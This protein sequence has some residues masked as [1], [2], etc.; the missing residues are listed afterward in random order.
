MCPPLPM[1]AGAHVCRPIERVL[2]TLLQH[3][4]QHAAC[5]EISKNAGM[6]LLQS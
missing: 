5:S 2:Y 1:P 4:L 6:D 3:S